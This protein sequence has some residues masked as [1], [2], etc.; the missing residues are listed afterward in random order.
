MIRKIRKDKKAQ[1]EIIGFGIILVIIAIV[2]VILISIS[3]NKNSNTSSEDFEITSFLKVLME[4]STLC[5]KN[6][7]LVPVKDLIFECGRRKSCEN[8]LNS[9]EV[10][11]E[12]ISEAMT[13]NWKIVNGSSTKGYL[14]LIYYEGDLQINET[15][16]IV[17]GNFK[18]TSQNYAKTS[19]D[20]E[21][22]LKIYD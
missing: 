15:K 22:Y 12:T 19:E 8:E 3:I 4:K 14:I 2:A 5:E 18:G 9:C 6:G 7:N 10:L 20:V 1:E 17:E 21:I 13:D 11:N 16:G